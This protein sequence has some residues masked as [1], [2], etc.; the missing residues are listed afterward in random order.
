MARGLGS[1]GRLAEPGHDRCFA[2]PADCNP[3][4]GA[5]GEGLLLSDKGGGA[6]CGDRTRPARERKYLRSSSDN[7]P[8]RLHHRVGCS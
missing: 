7:M 4:H 6:V 1:D 3:L 2:G 5:E 8:S